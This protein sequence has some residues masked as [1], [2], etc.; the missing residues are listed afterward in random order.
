[1]ECGLGYSPGT[2]YPEGQ[3][4]SAV[5]STRTWQSLGRRGWAHTCPGP[6]LCRCPAPE[7][8][9]SAWHGMDLLCSPNTLHGGAPSDP[10]ERITAPLPCVPRGCPGQL[11]SSSAPSSSAWYL[12]GLK[13]QNGR[14]NLGGRSGRLPGWPCARRRAEAQGCLPS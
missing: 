4:P 1:M 3:P 6:H 2:P 13:R 5:Q 11:R 7:T 10:S 14:N 8:E 9:L 12:R